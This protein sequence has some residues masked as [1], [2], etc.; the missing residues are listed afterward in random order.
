LDHELGQKGFAEAPILTTLTNSQ[1]V[2]YSDG[3]NDNND[4]CDDNG[5]NGN[6]EMV[7]VM[8]MGRKV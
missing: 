8:M 7:V 6:S 4:S 2:A 3:D 1:M 5:E